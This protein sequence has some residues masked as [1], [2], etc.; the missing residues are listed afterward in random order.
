MTPHNESNSTTNNPYF[1]GSEFNFEYLTK[2]IISYI[3]STVI[4]GGEKILAAKLIEDGFVVEGKALERI[5]KIRT[6]LTATI[7]A[8]DPSD[9]VPTNI[10]RAASATALAELIAC[11]AETV[12]TTYT[13]RLGAIATGSAVIALSILANEGA[14]MLWGTDTVDLG[15]LIYKRAV[16]YASHPPSEESIQGLK[17]YLSGIDTVSP[18]PEAP[19]KAPTAPGAIQSAAEAIAAGTKV[20]TD[21]PLAFDLDG[22]G[23]NLTAL[24]ASNTFFDLD[25]GGLRER[26]Q[27]IEKEDG[28]LTLDLNKNGQIDNKQELFGDEGKFTNGFAK[29]RQYNQKYYLYRVLQAA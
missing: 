3:P 1:N 9:D 29:L 8:I 15:E 11:E 4:D 26:T 12:L 23:I 25:N 19:S 14:Q 2:R 5:L 13:P 22:D 17:L 18:G 7:G 21:T 16:E 10:T 28:L 27:W 24:N 6:P 20:P